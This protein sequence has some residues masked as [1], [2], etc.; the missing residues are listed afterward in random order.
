MK[1][2]YIQPFYKA[3][4]DVFRIM[5]DVEVK[6]GELRLAQDLIPSKEAN[7]I[8][9]TTGDLSG[10]ILYSFPKDMTLTMVK[11]MSGME[12]KELDGFVLSALGE[13]ANIISG[14][15]M[16]YLNSEN[17]RGDISPP[18]VMLGATHTLSMATDVVLVIPMVSTIGD[19][20]INVSL[21]ETNK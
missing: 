18:H 15:A 10:S 6:R 1:A 9:G 17:Y 13:V 21:R 19:F 20:D 2:A 12:L 5:M 11:I 3:T 14:N 16:T 4:R 7:V 8:I